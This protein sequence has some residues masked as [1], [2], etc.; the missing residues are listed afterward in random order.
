MLP[1]LQTTPAASAHN[2]ITSKVLPRGKHWASALGVATRAA[3]QRR[4]DSGYGNCPAA[5]SPA[6][7]MRKGMRGEGEWEW[8]LAV[9][10]ATAIGLFTL[11][12]EACLLLLLA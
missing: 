3:S 7:D 12:F 4:Q 6:F 10:N 11:R 2:R 9:G 5:P 8:E 1:R